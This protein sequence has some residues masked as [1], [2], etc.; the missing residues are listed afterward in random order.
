MKPRTLV[1]RFAAATTVVMA[2]GLASAPAAVAQDGAPGMRVKEHGTR[3]KVTGPGFVVKLSKHGLD[4]RINE[5]RFGDP[6]SG[7]PIQRQTL[8]LTGRPA[9]P[10]ECENGTYTVKTGTFERTFRFSSTDPRPLPYPPEF[11]AGF[12]GILTPFVGVIKGTVTNAEGETLNF[13]ISDLAQEV[14]TEDGFSATAPIHGLFIDGRG[15]IRDHI[16]LVGRFNSGPNG[17][18]ATYRIEDRGTCRQTADLPYGPDSK[19]VLVTGPIFVFPFKAPVT[20]P[21]H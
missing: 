12:P 8:D 3:V 4:V 13:L 14:L 10:F 20:T 21:R 18:N 7:Y 17:E 6:D 16:S 2:F 1:T 19:G 9:R 5:D 11:A 15:R